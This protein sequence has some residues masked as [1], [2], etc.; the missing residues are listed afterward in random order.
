MRRGRRFSPGKL[1]ALILL[2]GIFLQ[3]GAMGEV[4]LLREEMIALDSVFKAVLDAIIREDL[5]LI[6]PALARYGEAR[7]RLEAGERTGYRILLPKNHG[8]MGDFFN[9]RDQFQVGLEELSKAAETGQKKVAK[10]LTH[11]LLDACVACHERFR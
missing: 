9:L 2:M 6:Q 3:S 7:D 4:N 1:G 11:K 10:N 8:R 5:R